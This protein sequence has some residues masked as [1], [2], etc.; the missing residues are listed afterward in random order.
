MP[1]PNVM[2]PAHEPALYN[3]KHP[4]S[5]QCRQGSGETLRSQMMKKAERDEIHAKTRVR[6]HDPLSYSPAV[7]TDEEETA[8]D[9]I[10]RG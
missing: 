2:H 7:L 3:P 5:R 1:P 4:C 10:D 9:E 8:F 6:Q